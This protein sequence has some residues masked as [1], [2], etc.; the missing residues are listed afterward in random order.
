MPTVQSS[1]S[2]CQRLVHLIVCEVLEPFSLIPVI[3]FF[4]SLIKLEAL[5]YFIEGKWNP[6]LGHYLHS[7][8]RILK[9]GSLS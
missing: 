3:A 4:P 6:N 2:A 9:F 1:H 8:V 5:D 7:G